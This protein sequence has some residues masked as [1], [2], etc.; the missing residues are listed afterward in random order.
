M[1]IKLIS[2][3]L[4]L[5]DTSTQKAVFKFPSNFTSNSAVVSLE[6]IVNNDIET[7]NITRTYKLDNKILTVDLPPT[8]CGVKFTINNNVIY[9][10]QNINYNFVRPD[11]DL[12]LVVN[13]C[14]SLAIN[15]SGIDAS[16][17]PKR[18]T[19]EQRGPTRTSRAM[20]MVHMA[21]MESY[22]VLNGKYDSYLKLSRIFPNSNDINV[23]TRLTMLQTVFLVLTSLYS[24]QSDILN[25]KLKFIM[26]KITNNTHK[27][28]SSLL[29]LTISKAI[30]DNRENDGSEV[31][32]KKWGV[33][34]ETP[35]GP[36]FWTNDPIV[37]SQLA[38]GSDWGNVRP[39]ILK[40]ANQIDIKAPPALDSV[41]YMMS[42]NS[43]KALGGDPKHTC[44]VRSTTETVIG[45]YWAYDGAPS[46]CAPTRLYN[47]VAKTILYDKDLSADQIL[48]SFAVINI[49]MADTAISCWY[50]KYLYKYWRPVTAI[51]NASSDGNTG[52]V[53][54]KDW[55]P[56]GIPN[57]KV[58]QTPPF[59][60]Y[61]SGH[62]CFGGT[63]FEILKLKLNSD[64]VPFTFVSD[65]Y[66]GHTENYGSIL[67]YTPRTFN[68]L[69]E[70]EEENGKSR[71]YLGVH[72]TFEST[73]GSFL[74]EEIGAYVLQNLYKPL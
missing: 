41:E 67:P 63:L 23:L 30:L 71:I 53:E 8:T 64:N 44:T 2:I 59:P 29:S 61:P 13:Y 45:N 6:A 19:G 28:L 1:S 25:E 39:F 31:P 35:V 65:E 46:L 18:V 16:N 20:A 52:T 4:D 9:C 36:G 68:T 56:A 24:S 34:Y 3:D 74:G 40:S 26:D 27:T 54:D 17:D 22:I 66:N 58:N 47:Q 11:K 14:N 72:F 42:Y 48:H 62:A 73:V 55:V 21:M 50:Y 33:N 12:F 38:L 51:R 5:V 43:V 7:K 60:S 69:S 15:T 37:P 49:A 32:D 57:I 10:P 70:A